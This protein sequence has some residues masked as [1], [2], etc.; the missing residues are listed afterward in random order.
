MHLLCRLFFIEATNH[1]TITP[2]HIAGTQNSLADDQSHD[3]LSS[4]LQ[5][6]PWSQS[7]ATWIPTSLPAEL[8]IT[9]GHRSFSEQ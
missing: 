3:W 8:K 6:A 4:F 2:A 7:E 5:K 9:V 1:F